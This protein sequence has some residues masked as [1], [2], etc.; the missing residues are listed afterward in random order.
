MLES[1]ISAGLMTNSAQG[2]AGGGGSNGCGRPRWSMTSRVSGLRAANCPACFQPARAQQVHRHRVLRGRRQHPVD[3][4][5][6]RIG[7][8]IVAHDDPDAKTAIMQKANDAA[9]EK[10]GSAKYC[11]NLPRHEMSIAVAGPDAI[12][13]QPAWPVAVRSPRQQWARSVF[14]IRMFVFAYARPTGS[15]IYSWVLLRVG[16]SSIH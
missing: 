9:A 16:Y 15:K 3:A 5:V 10:P 7:R 2:C 13:F 8:N 12:A 4:G 14:Y 6:G 1:A 11:D